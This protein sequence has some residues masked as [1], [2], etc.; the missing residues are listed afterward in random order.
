MF[1]VFVGY[2][3][4]FTFWGIRSYVPPFEAI[5]INIPNAVFS[6][7]TLLTSSSNIFLY[8]APYSLFKQLT[9]V[10]QLTVEVDGYLGACNWPVNHENACKYEYV[11]PQPVIYTYM[12]SQDYK[13]LTILGANFNQL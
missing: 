9:S 12:A 1:G 4:V 8:P 6:D 11:A 7:E 2:N 13:T 3:Y 5:N 10:P